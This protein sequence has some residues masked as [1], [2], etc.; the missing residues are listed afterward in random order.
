MQQWLDDPQSV[1]CLQEIFGYSLLAD[2]SLQKMFFLLG[3]RRS[4]KGTI[5]RILR[6]L[7]GAHNVAAPTL[8]SLQGEFGLQPLLNRT[9]AVIGDARLSGRSDEAQI[10]ERILSITGEDAQTITVADEKRR[11]DAEQKCR[12]LSRDLVTRDVGTLSLCELAEIDTLLKSAGWTRGKLAQSVEVF[13]QIDR[14]QREAKAVDGRQLE[15][16]YTA[17]A[18]ANEVAAS[19]LHETCYRPDG[20]RDR[21]RAEFDASRERANAAKHSLEQF[22]GLELRLRQLKDQN[23]SLLIGAA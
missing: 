21:L 23:A 17:A 13:L 8:G 4:G 19:A 20:E 9:L 11:A 5:A 7:V 12:V 6:G 22:R 1:D 14:L 3:P 10:V 15:S 18:K 16:E 2:T